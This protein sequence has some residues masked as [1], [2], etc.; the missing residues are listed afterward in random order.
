M[1]LVLTGQILQSTLR[2]EILEKG[3]GVLEESTFV[4]DNGEELLE[5]SIGNA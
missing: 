4:L 3:E 5:E 2:L 1:L